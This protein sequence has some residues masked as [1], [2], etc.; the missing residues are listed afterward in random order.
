MATERVV[1]GSGIP[2]PGARIVASQFQFYLDGTDN[3]R[4]EGWNS[5]TA[6]ALQVFGRYRDDDGNVKTFEASLSLTGDR[7][8]CSRDVP[9]IRGYVMNLAAYSVGGPEHFGETFVKVSIIR[10][11]TGA[12]IV[13]GTLLQGYVTVRQSLSWPGSPIQAMSEF[14]GFMRSVI[15]V[16][17]LPGQA[18]VFT[19]PINTRWDVLKIT[20]SLLTDANP[21]NRRPYVVG[22]VLSTTPYCHHVQQIPAGTA[23]SFHW[24]RGLTG[25]VDT[26]AIPGTSA[27]PEPNITEYPGLVTV[28]ATGLLAGDQFLAGEL[29]ALERL[30]VN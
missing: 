11:L 13:I 24:A 26:A 8:L 29:V 22:T 4:L 28:S 9:A 10:G 12:T 17:A 19:C 14:P 7:L 27:L 1:P 3:L 23:R 6:I 16:G 2:L 15:S 20:A 30:E 21:G 18:M 5:G 25:N